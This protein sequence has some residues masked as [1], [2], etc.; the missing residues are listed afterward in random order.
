[1]THANVIAA[2]WRM[3]L[4]AP[5]LTLVW[6]SP[7]SADKLATA[8]GE[9]IVEV[10]HEVDINV[11]RGLATLHV[12]RTFE[13]RGEQPDQV[14]TEF[15]LPQGATA[16][17]LRI[18][19]RRQWYA[20]ELME[21]EM[22]R[23]V[24]ESLTGYG[25]WDLKDPAILFWNDLG[26]LGL[27]VFPVT[28]GQPSTVEYTLLV[29][30]GYRNGTYYLAYPNDPP[31]VELAVPGAVLHNSH[32][33]TRFWINGASAAAGQRVALG[34]RRFADERDHG[35]AIDDASDATLGDATELLEADDED[36]TDPASRQPG[37]ALVAISAPPI[38][39]VDVRFGRFD[40]NVGKHLTWLDVD[41][42]YPLRPAP[43]RAQVVFV[44]DA[45]R[46]FDSTGVEAALAFAGAFVEQ[47]PD[48]SVEVVLFAR[49]ARRLFGRFVATSEWPTALAAARERGVL[50]PANGSF[51]ERGLLLA[52]AALRPRTGPRR[53][54]AITDSLL[55]DA[56]RNAFS[57]QALSTL[58][59]DRVVHLVDLDP[60]SAGDDVN[61]E[62]DDAHP[63]APVPLNHGGILYVVNGGGAVRDYQRSALELVRPTRIDGF[64]IATE[65]GLERAIGAPAVLREG[66]G[67]RHSS[68]QVAAA[69]HVTLQGR[70]WAEPFVRVVPLDNTFSHDVLP[71]LLFGT[72]LYVDLDRVE[73]LRAATAGKAVSPVTSYLSIEPGIRPS[74]EGFAL[75][76]DGMGGFGSGAAGLGG[77]A[78]HG[79]QMV[80]A[81]V[82]RQALL[83]EL[84]RQAVAPCLTRLP[85]PEP[86]A[87]E[88]ETT[89]REIVDLAIGEAPRELATCAEETLW[90][91]AL[92]AAFT[93]QRE[94]FSA[95]IE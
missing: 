86:L 12:R 24:Y 41:T 78:D 92:P 58:T 7:T 63:L 33:A 20:G 34:Q 75:D 42:A 30:L 82:D 21:A 83:I 90:A 50:T 28:P 54:I 5:L 55:R 81:E 52:S 48:A 39:V 72:S 3:Q 57:A 26:R 14:E 17:A 8:R 91:I 13:N 2:A 1:M 74:R 19:G 6:A 15:T 32:R 45:S 49:H 89:Y 25:P 71:A 40:L 4:L 56:Y 73:L 43:R 11:G 70:I 22:A 79:I 47:L 60:G 51:L 76:G 62:R 35:M 53:I 84:V 27:F 37:E 80:G 87:I 69:S 64:R 94:H 66:V 77:K 65:E 38:D 31:Q 68:I 59:G 18:K 85:A 9:P 61:A 44:I 93:E 95:E 29:P 88:V 67:L 10:A 16:T 46:S 23:V 36:D